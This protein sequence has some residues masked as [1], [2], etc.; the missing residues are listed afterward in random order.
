MF[1]IFKYNNLKLSFNFGGDFLIN[2]FCE[3]LYSMELSL[4][5]LFSLLGISFLLLVSLLIFGLVIR[6]MIKKFVASKVNYVDN[7]VAR[8][9][10][11]VL[12]LDNAIKSAEKCKLELTDRIEKLRSQL[13]EENKKLG[14]K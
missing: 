4:I 14:V 7:R 6:S 5:I 12:I 3:V 11:K 13:L 1:S 8:Q 9:D 2:C 10:N